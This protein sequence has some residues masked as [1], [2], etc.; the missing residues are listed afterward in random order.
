MNSEV[1]LLRLRSTVVTKVLVVH[2]LRAS[3][4]SLLLK[5]RATKKIYLVVVFILRFLSYS[6]V[7]I[8]RT[9]FLN[10]GS[11]SYCYGLSYFE[12]IVESLSVS[13]T[14]FGGLLKIYFIANRSV[15]HKC[16][17]LLV[18]TSDKVIYSVYSRS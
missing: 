17:S 1:R 11:E 13:V 3:R 14:A 4:A 12:L 8:F 15:L 9:P 16:L 6:L 7:N 5:F 10:C 2:F 18:T